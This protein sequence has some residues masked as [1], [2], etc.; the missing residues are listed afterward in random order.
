[1]ISLKKHT[2]PANIPSRQGRRQTGAGFIEVLVALVILAIGLL[3]VLSMQSRGLG[4]NQRAIFSSE[5]NML[6]ADMADR[7]LSYG[8]SGADT[9]EFDTISSEVVPAFADPVVN[10]HAQDW[11]NLINNTVIANVN[12]ITNNTSLP[13]PV[14]TVVWDGVRSY[15]VTIQW[16]DE[17]TGIV[18]RNCANNARDIN[19]NRITLT[20]FQLIVTM[21]G[22]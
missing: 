17:R 4:S 21:A 8:I 10:R 7:I 6:A 1:M 22:Q 13:T 5:V 9:G 12:L 11:S 15:T 3:G 16:D 20:C 2:F 18:A 14:G 19:G